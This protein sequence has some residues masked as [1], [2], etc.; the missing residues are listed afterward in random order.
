MDKKKTTGLAA[1]EKLTEIENNV[2]LYNVDI[3]IPLRSGYYTSTTAHAAIPSEIRKLGLI[4]TYKTDSTT[5]VTEQFTGSNLSAWTTETNWTN[6]GSEGGNKILEWHTDSATTRKQILASDRKK[7]M[8]ISYKHPDYGWINEQYKGTS[9][10]DSQW[11]LDVNW[12]KL[13]NKEDLIQEVEKRLPYMWLTWNTD[14]ATTRKQVPLER[15]RQ[16]MLIIYQNAEKVWICEQYTHT[17]FIDDR[18][19][20][21]SYWIKY[22]NSSDINDI[23]DNISSLAVFSKRDINQI[24]LTNGYHINNKQGVTVVDLTPIEDEGCAYAIIEME[25]FKNYFIQ[26]VGGSNSEYFLWSVT[27]SN[28]KVLA[29][30]GPK[31]NTGLNP[32]VIDSLKYAVGSKL[33]INAKINNSVSGFVGVKDNDGPFVLKEITS[34]TM[35]SGELKVERVGELYFYEP[36][37]ELRYVVYFTSN[38]VFS[39]IKVNDIFDGKKLLYNGEYVVFDNANSRFIPYNDKIYFDKLNYSL[40]NRKYKN[41]KGDIYAKSP[42]PSNPTVGD[43][44][45]V[46]EESLSIMIWGIETSYNSILYYNGDTFISEKALFLQDLTTPNMHKYDVCIVGGGAGGIGAAYALKDSGL[47]VCLI[48]REASLGGTHINAYIQEWLPTPAAPFIKTLVENNSSIFTISGAGGDYN[49]TLYWNYKTQQRKGQIQFDRLRLSELYYDELSPTIDIFLNTELTDAYANNG[50]CE[51]ITAK[52]RLTGGDFKIYANKFIDACSYLCQKANGVENTGW[53]IGSDGKD[54]F[55]EDFYE[56]GEGPDRYAINPLEIAF[57]VGKDIDG[58][59]DI[60]KY[61]VI[62]GVNT[63]ING[64]F[65]DRANTS[66][67]LYSTSTGS[68]LSTQRFIDEG[69][70][71]SYQ[72][73]LI[74]AKACWAL[75]KKRD[76]SLLS[77]KYDRPAPILGIRERCR[78]L[79]DKMMVQNDLNVRVTSE[80]DILGQKIIALSTWYVDIHGKPASK[81]IPCDCCGIPYDCII[82]KNLKNVLISCNSLGASHIAAAQIRLTK[83]IMSVGYAAGFAIIDTISKDD[84]RDADISYI[85]DAIQIRELI[86]VMETLYDTY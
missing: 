18:W 43:F 62:P 41:Y 12:V 45:I 24:P 68:N 37:K 7:G 44:Y 53:Y 51:Y 78:I 38:T 66:F 32:I 54:R 26:G 60:S 82:P 40:F 5:S 1:Q 2:G 73:G 11:G 64:Y 49:K 15:R 27:D 63:S 58:S 52:N 80:T 10:T 72:Q 36:S 84:V 85:Q 6:V 57:R 50:I 61:P 13:P 48:E 22:V 81:S 9:L 30:S 17:Y 74:N 55:N 67:R 21:D 75:L 34:A 29:S 3:N 28:N 47:K 33:I 31:V 59:E 39:V 35:S 19:G 71:S 23:F 20:N 56:D 86:R 79:C 77:L 4:I 42:L 69:Y 14:V 8:Q 83:T 65:S 70:E 16:G 46:K 76:S 25:P